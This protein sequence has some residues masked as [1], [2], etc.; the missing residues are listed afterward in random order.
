MT[1]LF[2]LGVP[3]L[4]IWNHFYIKHC[5]FYANSEDPDQTPRV[6][7]SDLGLYCLPLSFISGR[8][9]LMG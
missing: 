1:P 3:G 8:L 2:I 7:A 6:A 9:S 5:K 4:F